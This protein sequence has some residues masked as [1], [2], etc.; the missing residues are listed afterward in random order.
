[1]LNAGT[2]LSVSIF[3]P[4]AQWRENKFNQNE[5]GRELHRMSKGLENKK[6]WYRDLLKE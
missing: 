2:R 6:I 1:M 5:I 3:S 4:K